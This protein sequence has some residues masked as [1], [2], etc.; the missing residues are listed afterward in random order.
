VG[1]YAPR[2]REEIV[3]PRRLVGASGRPLNFTVRPQLQ[4]MYYVA[5]GLLM[6][7]LPTLCVIADGI[8]SPSNSLVLLIGK[9]FV[10]W[11]IGARLLIA[12][13]R[14]IVQPRYTAQVILGL[15]TEESFPLVR[16]LG[17]ANLS[18]GLIGLLSIAFPIWRLPVALAGGVFYGLAG[19]N[20]FFQSHRNRLENVAMVSDVFASIVL[21]GF[22]ANALLG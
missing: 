18:L 8:A 12:G 4:A 11:A 5:V 7:A 16:E 19:G 6:F 10:F 15:K 9:W 20:H 21:L 22:C 3:R 14:Q 2:A 17:F 1:G 13:L